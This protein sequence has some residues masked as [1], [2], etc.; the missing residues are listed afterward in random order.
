MSNTTGLP[1]IAP[2]PDIDAPG[3]ARVY[4]RLHE[5]DPGFHPEKT[6]ILPASERRIDAMGGPDFADPEVMHNTGLF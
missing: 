5:G 3:P 2:C 6:G 1:E 4:D